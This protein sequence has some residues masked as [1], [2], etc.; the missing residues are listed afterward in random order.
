MKTHRNLNSP[1]LGR[2]LFLLLIG[3]IYLFLTLP[4]LLVIPM[5]FGGS[6]SLSFPPKEFSLD[7]YRQFFT[8]PVWTGSLLESLRVG[9]LTAICAT[10]I[11]SLS[12]YGLMRGTFPGKK[13]LGF[14]LLSPILLPAI[15]IGLGIYFYFS[16]LRITGTTLGLVLAHSVLTI[17]YVIVTVSSGLKQIDPRV[18][19][20]AEMMGASSIRIFLR[21]V[22]P[23]IKGSLLGAAL[24]AFL[25]SFDEV[26]IAWLISG[27]NAATLPVVM[28]SSLKVEVS[29]VIAAA[30]TML[31]AASIVICALAGLAQ[32]KGETDET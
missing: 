10:I 4:S 28:Y 24:F 7:L 9:A 15:V 23:Q 27:N 20:A 2:W 8:S 3:L 31:S 25:I 26:V 13:F 11:G 18:E 14:V 30:A 17:P 19:L 5:S 21:V 1:R 32:K 22:V 12:A 6:G 29:P 16:Y